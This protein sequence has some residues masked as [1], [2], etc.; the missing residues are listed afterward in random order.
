MYKKSG[1]AMISCR[2]PK[3][4]VEEV[5]EKENE[6]EETEVEDAAKTEIFSRA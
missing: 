5:A 6:K 4:M 1:H 3:P 2:A